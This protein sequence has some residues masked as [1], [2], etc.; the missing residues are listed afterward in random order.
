MTVL[1]EYHYSGFGVEDIDDAAAR[2]ADPDFQ[3]R[4][5]RGDTQILGQQALALQGS[6]PINDTWTASLLVLESPGDGS[7][8][9]SP[10]LSWDYAENATF[11]FSGFAPWGDDPSGGQIESEYGGS[12]LSLFVQ[13]SLYY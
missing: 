7:G 5:L 4:I 1:A 2:L 10:S 11:V 12:P 9:V 13:L 8:V 3:K 6:Y